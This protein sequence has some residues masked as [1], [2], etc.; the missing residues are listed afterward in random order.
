MTYGYC[1][2]S[3]P[4]QSIDRQERNIKA[5]FPDAYIVKEAYTGKTMNRPE[6]VKL[7]KHIQSGDTIVFDSVSRMA[8]DAD[9]GVDAYMDLMGKGVELVFLKEA[10]VNTEAYKSAMQATVP[11]TGEEIADIYIEAT[12]KVLKILAEKQIRLAFGQSEKEVTDLRQRTKEGIVSA[13]LRGEI[14]GRRTGTKVETK[15]AKAAKEDIRRLYKG[16]DGANTVDEVLRITGISRNS[17][18]KY[19]KELK[20]ESAGAAI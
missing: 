13:K 12:N 9:E 3:T 10:T 17:F 2:I 18:F 5:K 20:E 15:K 1:R 7:M 4:A 6:W 8:R 14:V 16:F 11:M 19:C